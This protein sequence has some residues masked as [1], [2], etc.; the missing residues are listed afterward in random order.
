LKIRSIDVVSEFKQKRYDPNF[1][2]EED[3][4]L[5]EEKKKKAVE[6]KEPT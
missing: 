2:F 5:F 6:T 1:N 4:L 3:D